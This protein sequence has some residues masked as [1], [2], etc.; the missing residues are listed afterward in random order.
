MIYMTLCPSSKNR[1]I[2]TQRD[3]Y[4]DVGRALRVCIVE[5]ESTAYVARQYANHGIF[6]NGIIRLSPEY[7]YANQAFLD[8]F[9]FDLLV[10]NVL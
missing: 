7:I 4:Q 8:E 3:L 5:L 10:Y 6:A 2:G 9:S 1:S